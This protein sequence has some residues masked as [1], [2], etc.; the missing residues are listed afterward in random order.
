MPQ[1][2]AGGDGVQSVEPL[3]AKKER[4]ERRHS[5][6]WWGRTYGSETVEMQ[7][8]VNSLDYLIDMMPIPYPMDDYISMLKLGGNLILLGV[9]NAPL[10]FLS[11]LLMSDLNFEFE[12]ILTSIEELHTSSFW[13]D[14]DEFLVVILMLQLF[15]L[16]DENFEA[17]EKALK[18]AI[19]L[20]RVLSHWGNTKR[21]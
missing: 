5:W 16:L 15:N 3:W 10:Q 1:L 21:V 7:V 12:P 2:C 13:I 19:S 11:P 9:V 4:A 8:A 6:T 17:I 18:L 20:N 14:P